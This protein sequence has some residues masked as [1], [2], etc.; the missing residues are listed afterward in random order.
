[1]RTLLLSILLAFLTYSLFGQVPPA[2]PPSKFDCE[3]LGG[4]NPVLTDQ[5][6]AGVDITQAWRD[7]SLETM[8]GHAGVNA[9]VQ[10]R[11]G[12]SLPTIVC[13]ILQVTD[14]ELQTGSDNP[15]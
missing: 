15:H 13:A 8:V 10:F 5:E 1:M 2:S 7:K 9:S 3:L 6:R 14:I 11:F 4:I 12:E